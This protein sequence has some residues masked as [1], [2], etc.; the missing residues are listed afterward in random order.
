MSLL[1]PKRRRFVEE[2]LVDFNATQA[3]KRAG[4]ADKSAQQ[5]G[6]DLLSN[7]LIAEA[8]REGME[9]F[10]RRT[11]VDKDKIVAELARLGF[12]DLRELVAWS[13]EDGVTFRSSSHVDEDAARAVKKVKSRKRTFYTKNGDPIVTV[14]LEIELHGK[15]EAL[16]D[17][18]R[19]LGM[20]TDRH[21]LVGDI[22]FMVFAPEGSEEDT[23]D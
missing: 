11:Y 3:A 12:S 17:L 16:R 22:P 18:G 7:P 23:E 8:I 15:V 13:P 1:S 5:Q 14:E 9:E 4:Y 20:F 6:S 21:E 10:R 2:Y 19:H